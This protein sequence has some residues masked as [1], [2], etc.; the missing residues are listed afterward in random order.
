MSQKHNVD[1]GKSYW[2]KDATD[3]NLNNLTSTSSG[4][5]WLHTPIDSA[6]PCCSQI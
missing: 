5:D 2:P 3:V 4:S 6:K 1:M